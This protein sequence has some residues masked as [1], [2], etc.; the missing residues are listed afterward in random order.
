MEPF[1]TLEEE[2]LQVVVVELIPQ[3]YLGQVQQYNQCF[4]FLVYSPYMLEVA[5][6][7]GNQKDVKTVC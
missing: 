2:L 5:S 1:Q 6:L 3:L 4:T 7:E